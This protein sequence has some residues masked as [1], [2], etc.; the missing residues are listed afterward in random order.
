[1]AVPKPH[2]PHVNISL[3][4]ITILGGGLL[5]TSVRCKTVI[6]HFLFITKK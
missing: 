4:I 5:Y 3:F 1:M 6:S 2:H